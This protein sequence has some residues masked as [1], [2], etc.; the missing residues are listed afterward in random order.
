MQALANTMPYQF[1]NNAKTI[2]FCMLLYCL[3][4]ITHAVTDICF[5]YTFV[6]GFFRNLQKL[7]HFFG[8]L[9]NS[10]GISTVAVKAF[11]V[12]S[13]INRNYVSIV[14]SI[15]TGHAMHYSGVDGDAE[16][17]RKTIVTFERRFTTMITD[18]LFCSFVQR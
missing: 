1:P 18:K 13:P 2:L 5:G 6:K 8:Y 12:Y 9:P 7:L 10:M 3:A 4:Y 14:Q 16:A 11:I 15:A 17:I